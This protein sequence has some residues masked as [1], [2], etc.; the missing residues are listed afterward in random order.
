M[1]TQEALKVLLNEKYSIIPSGGGKEGKRP[2][3]NQW[4]PYQTKLPSSETMRRW[5][6]ELKPQMWGI[7]TGES[8]GVVIVDADDASAMAILEKEGLKPHVRTPR[9]G[10]HYY[11]QHPGHHVINKAGVLPKL[12]IRG[13]GGFCNVIG[14]NR[15]TGGEYI[16]EIMPTRDNI[17][18]WSKMPIRILEAMN[19]E[20]TRPIE[21]PGA[22]IP[23]GQRN[24]E[25]T[26]IAGIMRSAGMTQSEMLTALLEVNKNRG[27]PPLGEGEV[28]RIAESVSRYKPK[29]NERFT[30]TG[31]AEML[32]HLYG[33]QLRYD[34]RRKRWL[35]WGH[36]HWKPDRDGKVSRLAIDAAR[37]RFA[38]AS[39][40]QSESLKKKMAG[41]A[42]GSENRIRIEACITIAQKI[43]PFADIGLDW[44]TNRM[45]LGA[46]NG[47]IDLKTGVLR[48]GR[49]EDKITM[50]TGLNFDPDAK[51]PRW[52][53][54][55]EEVFDDAELRDWILRA[56]GY[57]ITGDT[58]EQVVFMGHGRGGNGKSRFRNAVFT[59][60]GD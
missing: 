41:W 45:L 60:M 48:K 5:K 37:V 12:D 8:S 52:V 1:D 40:V 46:E 3:I 43:E 21:A 31:N 32:A 59:A 30:D 27:Q 35:V 15:V 36:H 23:E 44:D 9:G 25:L 33:D 54:F 28:Y 53:Q 11:F 4:K 16:I 14:K 17:Y 57:S 6:D 10:A 50:T 49:P 7:V 34:H 22:P 58:T 42:I 38:L 55:I 56:L 13:D 18:P 29:D 24:S 47:I 51:C 19:V 39:N 26:R 20:K 2:L